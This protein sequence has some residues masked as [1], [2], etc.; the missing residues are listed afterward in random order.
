MVNARM[1]EPGGGWRWRLSPTTP[2]GIEVFKQTPFYS[3]TWKQQV[4]LSACDRRQQSPVAA[5]VAKQLIT[6]VGGHPSSPSLLL[7]ASPSTTTS[8]S[9]L[10]R[11]PVLIVQHQNH[12][13]ARRPQL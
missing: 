12:E 2:V 10:R 6:Q 8:S 4:V 3:I 9:L 7:R 5:R 11:C 13:V 1:E